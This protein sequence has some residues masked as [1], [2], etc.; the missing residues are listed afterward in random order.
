M[1]EVDEKLKYLYAA[2]FFNLKSSYCDFS[3]KKS[4]LKKKN[5]KKYFLYRENG[6]EIVKTNL[7]SSMEVIEIIYHRNKQIIFYSDTKNRVAFII[8]KR[9]KY[10]TPKKIV[11]KVEKDPLYR[12][13]AFMFLTTLWFVGVL[14]FRDNKDIIDIQLSLGYQK[15]KNYKVVFLFPKSLRNRFSD[16]TSKLTL[17]LH[18]YVVRIPLKDIYRHYLKSSDIN[19]PIFIKVVN[20]DINYYYNYKADFIDAYDKNHF[21]FNTRSVKVGKTDTEMFLRKSVTGQFVLVVTSTLN[22]ST[23]V[24]EKLAF[25]LTLF[26]KHKEKYDIYFEKFAAG[27]AESGFEL[28]KYSVKQNANSIYILDKNNPLFK[29]IKEKYPKN[30]FAKNSFLAFY[31]IFLAR[32]FISSDLV[33]HVQRRL[34]DNDSLL[35]KKILQ[36]KYKFFLQHGVSLATNL[37]ERGYYNKKVPIAPDYIIVNSEFEQE[38]FRKNTQYTKEEL[39]ISGLPNIDLYVNSRKLPKTDITFLLTWRPWDLTGK[40]EKGS[41]FDRYLSFIK[42]VQSADFYKDKRMNIILH[43]KA[44][45][46]L[47]EQF[48]EFYEENKHY[49]YQG[50]IKDALLK[51]KVL[52]SDYSSVTYM[53]FAGGSNI[54]F[55]WE[56]KEKC[57]EEYGSPNILQE[58]IA[59][60]DIAYDFNDLEKLI[61]CNYLS[62]QKSRYQKKYSSLVECTEGKN[63]FNTFNKLTNILY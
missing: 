23:I 43:P 50:D 58:N 21:V 51:S 11:D 5:N 4:L 59:F 6:E 46:I 56:D 2:D 41:Y 62:K 53:A 63:T 25:G 12:S 20:E 24:K 28:F 17:L 34:Y 40:I 3:G 32:S 1:L 13:L 29:E 45:I 10:L 19:I 36:N 18:A 44:R 15:S 7:H 37:F 60:G 61:K 14:R 31:Y 55:Y 22:K 38:L 39:I 26:S 9:H 27:A 48:P 16:Y 47:Q 49:F 30:L 52:I 35:K 54:V 8:A 57:E 33:T 42:E